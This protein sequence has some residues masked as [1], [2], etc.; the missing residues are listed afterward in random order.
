[1]SKKKDVLL[2]AEEKK[3]LEK[4]QMRADME[5]RIKTAIKESLA[6]YATGNKEDWVWFSGWFSQ[7][8]VKADF[9]KYADAKNAKAKKEAEERKRKAEEKKKEKE[10]AEKEAAA[11][12]QNKVEAKPQSKPTVIKTEDIKKP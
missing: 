9:K 12:E 11:K 4:L 2:S 7:D 10:A 5:A 3:T 1:M 8:T 6:E